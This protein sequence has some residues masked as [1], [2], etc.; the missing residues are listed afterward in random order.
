MKHFDNYAGAEKY[1]ENSSKKNN[2]DRYVA[3]ANVSINGIAYY[4]YD[5]I[6]DVDGGEK[7]LAHFK[8][9]ERCN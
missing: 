8:N 1:A 9:G 4:V 2:E 3:K 6:T 5:K 7:I